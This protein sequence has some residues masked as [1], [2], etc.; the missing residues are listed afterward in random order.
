MAQEGQIALLSTVRR[1]HRWLDGYKLCT[2]RRWL[3]SNRYLL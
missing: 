2:M 1:L 3:G